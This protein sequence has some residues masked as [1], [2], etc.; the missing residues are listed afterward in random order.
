MYRKKFLE[1]LHFTLIIF[2]PIKMALVS[3]A[4]MQNYISYNCDT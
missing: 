2:F 3:F 4:D 1:L